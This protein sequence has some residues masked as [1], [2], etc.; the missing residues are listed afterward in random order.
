MKTIR[1]IVIIVVC[2]MVVVV[3]LVMLISRRPEVNIG[4]VKIITDKTTETL[5][6]YK[7]KSV[8]KSKK[9][10]YI[11]KSFAEI[12]AET[13]PIFQ[14]AKS[15]IEQGVI[16]DVTTAYEDTEAKDYYI[17]TNSEISITGN[18]ID[19]LYNIYDAKGTLINSDTKINIPVENPDTEEPQELFVE[20]SI[21]WGREKNYYQYN[22]YFKCIIS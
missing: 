16:N 10:D 14:Y 15:S 17:P 9:T 13:L 12:T 11:G 4:T 3:G 18:N 1:N 22:Y 19:V 8:Y 6:G 5:K 20:I 21:K 2:I 7:T